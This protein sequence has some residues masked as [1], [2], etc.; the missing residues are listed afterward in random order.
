MQRTFNVEEFKRS[1]P[2]NPAVR[3]EGTSTSTQVRQQHVGKRHRRAHFAEPKLSSTRLYVSSM[4][5][6]AASEKRLFSTAMRRLTISRCTCGR[7]KELTSS[8]TIISGSCATLS[9]S[10]TTRL[11]CAAL[12]LASVKALD[13]AAWATVFVSTSSARRCQAEETQWKEEEHNRE[14]N[15]KSHRVTKRITSTVCGQSRNKVGR[16]SKC[17]R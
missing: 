11:M 9:I 1:W 3:S 6:R 13:C 12:S 15:S 7:L 14:N 5:P 16:H 8:L 2:K 4:A 17:I 10:S